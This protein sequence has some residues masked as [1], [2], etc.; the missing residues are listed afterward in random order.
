MEQL[1][2]DFSGGFN[3]GSMIV[4]FVFGA[5]MI[6]ILALALPFMRG[7]RFES[8]LRAVRERRRQLSQNQTQSFQARA[9]LQAVPNKGIK[10]LALRGVS[11]AD[12]LDAKELR[13]K[14]ARAGKRGPSAVA[15]YLFK[16]IALPIIFVIVALLY[17]WLMFPE[18]PLAMRLAGVLV[19]GGLGYL[20][21][22]LLLSSAIT[23]R[24]KLL[25]RG[26]PDALDLIVICV[27]SGM[28]IEAA[29]NKVTDQMAESSPEM[30]EEMGLTSAEL[31]FLSDRRQAFE[32]LSDRTGLPSFKALA[33]TLLQS[34]RYGTPIANGLR[35]LAQENRDARM[36]LAEKKAAALPAQLTVPMIIFFLPVLFIIIA[37]PAAIQIVAMLSD[38]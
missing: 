24:Q 38:K 8:R 20:L 5:T 29:F 2:I 4:L 19:A 12:L 25:Q 22:Q 11:M 16:R 26:F 18:K 1:G 10:G 35:V 34:E 28:S 13:I 32:N 6:T 15:N 7:E 14:L 23:K 17:A 30:S 21:P 9:R 3:M 27:E 31:A 33:T 37:A 36:S